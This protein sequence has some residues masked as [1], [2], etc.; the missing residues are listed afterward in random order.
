MCETLTKALQEGT[1]VLLWQ[2]W[3][4]ASWNAAAGRSTPGFGCL[5]LTGFSVKNLFDFIGV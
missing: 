3:C 4:V 1:E 5:R 2:W